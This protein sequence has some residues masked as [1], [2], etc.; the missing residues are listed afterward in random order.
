MEAS[1]PATGTVMTSRAT[2]LL[3]IDLTPYVNKS[4]TINV[5]MERV[6]A[7]LRIGVRENS[8]ELKHVDQNNDTT[9]YATV[10]ITNY[11]LVNLNKQFY[12]F[13]HKISTWEPGTTPEF[14]LPDNFS[15]YNEE[16]GTYV[17]DP[18]FFKKTPTLPNITLLRNNYVSWF[19][20]FSTDNYASMPAA[21]SFGYGYILENT[22]Y[23][24]SQ[25]NG[26][27]TGI[28]FKAAINP[29][30][31]YLYDSE[32]KTLIAEKRPEY[33]PRTLYLYNHSFFGSI[34]ALNLVGGLE[35]DVLYPYTDSQ[36][37]PLGIKQCKFNMGSYETFYTYWIRDRLNPPTHMSSMEYAIVRNHYYMITV[38]GISGMGDSEIVPEIMRDNYPNSYEDIYVSSTPAG[39]YH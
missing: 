5:E 24:T 11:K 7:K 27:S 30:S 12:L 33:W 26:Y 3:G 1:L 32:T 15:D 4:Y 31:V 21:G 13:Q 19:G 35:L 28:V 29:K 22:S 20:D 23:A 9:V 10:N 8:F 6:L 17:V 14:K 39:N 25:K 2:A 36:L 37:K 38:I 34:A 16:D 18:L